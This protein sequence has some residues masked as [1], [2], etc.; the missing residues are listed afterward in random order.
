MFGSKD[1]L[2]E[3][4]FN[5]LQ[6]LILYLLGLVMVGFRFQTYLGMKLT[7]RRQAT[8]LTLELSL[9]LTGVGTLRTVIEL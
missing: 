8:L 6:Q 1:V 4:G 2:T 5:I 3:L 9:L 7:Q